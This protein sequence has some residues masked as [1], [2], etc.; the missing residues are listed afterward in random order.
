MSGNV[1]DAITD[2][3]MADIKYQSKF[4]LIRRNIKRQ[5][6]N[7]YRTFKNAVMQILIKEMRIKIQKR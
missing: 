5:K 6:V 4:D 3:R 2:D 7:V 1:V